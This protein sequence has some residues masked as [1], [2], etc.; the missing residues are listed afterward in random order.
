M[1]TETSDRLVLEAQSLNGEQLQILSAIKMIVNISPL[2]AARNR[3]SYNYGCRFWRYF[4]DQSVLVLSD[5]KEALDVV[6]DKITDTMNKVRHDKNFK[7]QFR[8]GKQEAR[9]ANFGNCSVENI[10]TISCS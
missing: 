9:T 1:D 6:E 4:E 5:K 7:T 2:R 3:K 10:K 8:L